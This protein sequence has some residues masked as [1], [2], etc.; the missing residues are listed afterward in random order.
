VIDI[1]HAQW[2]EHHE[3]MSRRNKNDGTFTYDAFVNPD[4]QS[5]IAAVVVKR[6]ASNDNS[7]TSIDISLVANKSAYGATLTQA[8]WKKYGLVGIDY[9][10]YKEVKECL[11]NLNVKVPS[12]LT[13]VLVGQEDFHID[14]DTAKIHA[15]ER[16]AHLVST[17]RTTC[18]LSESV[19]VCTAFL[20]VMCNELTDMLAPSPSRK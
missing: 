2:Q 17:F 5:S 20:E 16:L 10:P 14:A 11:V 4:R 18:V 1:K 12:H 6:Y 19:A 9:A 7:K 8:L 13:A 15:A 3:G